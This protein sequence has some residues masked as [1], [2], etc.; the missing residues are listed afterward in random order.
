MASKESV[1]GQPIGFT[2]K[3]IVCTDCRTVFTFTAA[4][5]G[6][7]AS[8]GFVGAPKRCS[9]CRGTRKQQHRGTKGTYRSLSERDQD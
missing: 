9:L 6:F 7:F 3:S 1:L 8:K 2:D 4:E 5:Q